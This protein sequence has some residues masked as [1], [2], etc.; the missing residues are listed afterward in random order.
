MVCCVSCQR[1]IAIVAIKEPIFLLSFS[2]L[3]NSEHCAKPCST[4]SLLSFCFVPVTQHS[5]FLS[6]SSF[7]LSVFQLP[8]VA[9]PATGQLLT[10][11]CH[12]DLGLQRRAWCWFSE[13]WP[14]L[15]ESIQGWP[16][17][18]C[19][20]VHLSFQKGLAMGKWK[21][22]DKGDDSVFVRSCT[23]AVFHFN[24]FLWQAFPLRSFWVWMGHS[25]TL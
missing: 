4:E 16:V 8:V 23:A 18:L 20:C 6:L 24:T 10:A 21:Q 2:L 22:P 12:S 7:S 15:G 17:P 11:V 25:S 14:S 1:M 3:T 5:C 9:H 13:N 19:V